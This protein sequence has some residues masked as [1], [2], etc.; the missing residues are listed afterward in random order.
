MSPEAKWNILQMEEKIT[1][2]LASVVH[3]PE[4]HFGRPFTTPYKI[5][6]E[7]QRMYPKD[8]SALGKEIGGEGIGQHHSLAQYIANQLSRRILDKSINTIEG[9]FLYRGNRVSLKNSSNGQEIL[10]SGQSSDL[11]IFRLKD[12]NGGDIY[13]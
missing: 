12:E 1:K 3:E 10:S 4:H 6:D 11:S 9:R 5:A 13:Q 2:I 8:F 7:F